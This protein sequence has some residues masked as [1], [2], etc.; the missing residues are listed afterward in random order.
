MAPLAAQTGECSE[1][2]RLV[3]EC[4]N[5]LHRPDG[6]WPDGVGMTDSN[7]RSGL[8]ACNVWLSMAERSLAE[9]HEEAVEALFG[10]K[11]TAEADDG[12]SGSNLYNEGDALDKRLTKRIINAMTLLYKVRGEVEKLR[13]AELRRAAESVP[14][15][16]LRVGLR[17]ALASLVRHAETTDMI[18]RP[19]IALFASE[20]FRRL[21]GATDEVL[22]LRARLHMYRLMRPMLQAVRPAYKVFCLARA[23]EHDVQNGA[24]LI[25]LQLTFWLDVDDKMSAML[26]TVDGLGSPCAEGDKMFRFLLQGIPREKFEQIGGQLHVEPQAAG[27]GVLRV[28]ASFPLTERGNR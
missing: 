15:N 1:T 6:E 26:L 23:D 10:E 5:N 4:N 21:D 17:P 12:G 16:L 14:L 11:S 18:P 3:S 28:E 8:A 9:A 20:A 22:V 7:S 2:V 24:G 27:A 13:E 25:P 19:Q